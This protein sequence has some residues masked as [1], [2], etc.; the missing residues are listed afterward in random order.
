MAYAFMMK[1][2]GVPWH[3]TARLTSQ[4]GGDVL[5]T[6]G[7]QGGVRASAFSLKAVVVQ[8]TTTALF[9]CQGGLDESPT[10]VLQEG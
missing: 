7:R 3:P 8:G 10:P 6:P 5:P 1:A 4:G 9:T 2:V